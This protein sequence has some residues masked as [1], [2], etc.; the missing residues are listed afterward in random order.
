MS[1]YI[2]GCNINHALNVGKHYI[3]KNKKPIINYAVEC[4]KIIGKHIKSIIK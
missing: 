4:K 1:R 2:A 3:N